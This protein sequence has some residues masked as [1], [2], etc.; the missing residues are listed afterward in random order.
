M[1][2]SKVGAPASERVTFAQLQQLSEYTHLLIRASR[3][4]D[5]NTEV[6]GM[7]AREAAARESLDSALPAARY[8]GFQAA[9]R[10]CMAEHVFLKHHVGLVREC[11]E[12]LGVA[13]CI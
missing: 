11:A 4:L 2:Y 7:L 12:R 9:L 5:L 13:V 6:L 1:R 3:A 8:R 10:A